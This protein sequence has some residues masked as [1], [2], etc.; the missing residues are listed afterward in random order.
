MNHINISIINK[1]L[2]YYSYLIPSYIYF[3]NYS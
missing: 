3:N 2:M 1:L